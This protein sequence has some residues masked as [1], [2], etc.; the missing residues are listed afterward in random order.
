MITITLRLTNIIPM[1]VL[2]F[3]LESSANYSTY[4]LIKESSKC[5]LTNNTHIQFYYTQTPIT[6][7]KIN[8]FQ[9]RAY[10]PLTHTPCEPRFEFDCNRS[11]IHCARC[12]HPFPPFLIFQR[13][14][15]S[16]TSKP[17]ILKNFIKNWL[18]S[19]PKIVTSSSHPMW[20]AIRSSLQLG[21]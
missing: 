17:F 15:V 18:F 21:W 14:V 6:S 10:V 4:K 13:G 16:K 20:F 7:S 8:I 3:L 1:Y 12:A 19:K 5:T 9:N 11:D 2:I